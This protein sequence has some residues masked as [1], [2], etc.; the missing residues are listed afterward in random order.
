M[1][2]PC[3]PLYRL[4]LG[5]TTTSPNTR[6]KRQLDRVVPESFLRTS[7]PSAILLIIII[8]RPAAAI[9]S[10]HP[11]KHNLFVQSAIIIENVNLSWK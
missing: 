7:R 2:I 5:Q 3:L 8:N 6:S 10:K 1:L 4:V 11:R 9:P